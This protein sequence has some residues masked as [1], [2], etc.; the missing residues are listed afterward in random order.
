MSFRK[1]WIVL[2]GCLIHTAP[3]ASAKQLSAHHTTNDALLSEDLVQKLRQKCPKNKLTEWLLSL[4]FTQPQAPRNKMTLASYVPYAGK[5]IGLIRLEKAGPL[6]TE[7]CTWKRLAGIVL[8]TT[9][10]WVILGQLSFVSGAKIVPQQLIDSQERLSNLAHIKD[11]QI[12]V[13]E[14]SNSKDHVD[15]HIITKDRF[16]ISLDLALDKPSLSLTHNNLFG[17]GHLLY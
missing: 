11:A 6:R 4:L 8:T 15:I 14:C 5:T 13:Q 9:Q 17:W 3:L 2:I 7:A 16:P 1:S 10:D 12:T